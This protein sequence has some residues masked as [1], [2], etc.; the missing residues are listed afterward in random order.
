MYVPVYIPV[1]TLFRQ[2]HTPPH[3]SIPL[4]TAP[5]QSILLLHTSSSYQVWG[6][7]D[8]PYRSWRGTHQCHGIPKT[9]IR[10][11]H[12]IVP[13]HTITIQMVRMMIPDVALVALQ[14]SESTQLT[15]SRRRG[16]IRAPL[17]VT[18]SKTRIII[19]VPTI[20]WIQNPTNRDRR[21]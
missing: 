16:A 4:V 11:H 14:L 10:P 3:L 15:P 9:R 8:S 19:P 7:G 5:Y 13:V 18:N 1:H 17:S 20:E 21:C 12:S 2:I 6:F